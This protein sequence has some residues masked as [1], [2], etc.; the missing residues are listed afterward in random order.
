MRISEI[1]LYSHRGDIRSVK[2]NE[3]GLSIITGESATGKSAIIH[4]IDYCFG[5]KNCHVPLGVIRDKVSWYGVHLVSG[6]AKVFVARKN[7]DLGRQTSSEIFI[8]SQGERTTPAFDQIK[9]NAN[10]EGLKGLLSKM[11]GLQE[12]LHVPPESNT[13][14]PLEANFSHGKIYCFQDQSLIDN[15]NQLFFSQQDGFVAQA[16]KDTLPFFLGAVDADELLKQTRLST[17][18]RSL[19]QLE[20]QQSMAV[21]WKEA[22]ID[23]AQAYLSEARQVR[24]IASENRPTDPVLVFETLSTIPDMN[25]ENYELID[26]DMELDELED[27]RGLLR[28]QYFL[29]SN[30]IEDALNL[31]AAGHDYG[32]ELLEQ[33]FRLSLVSKTTDNDVICP[34]CQ[35]EVGDD[36]EFLEPLLSDISEVAE[37]ISELAAHTPRLQKYISELEKRKDDLRARISV[38]QSQ[39]NALIEQSE[40]LRTARDLRSRQA[41][42]QGRISSFLES[43]ST[44][45]DLDDL[46]TKIEDI[47]RSIRRLESDISGENFHARLRN[48]ESNLET[49]ITDFTR[50]LELEHSAGRTRLDIQNL[51]VVSETKSRSIR[52]AEMGSGDNWVGCHVAVHMALHQWFRSKS[53]PVPSLLVLD[54]PSKAHYP[55]EIKQQSDITDDDRKAVSRLFR[56]LYDETEMDEPFQT[57]V[58]DHVDEKDDWFQSCVVERWRGGEKLVPETWPSY[59]E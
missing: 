46:Q 50:K 18:K 26:A 38:S 5:S 15:K 9:A 7:P 3:N 56:F 47:R 10:L 4:I 23:R 24:L 58:L 21:G 17:L 54:Q 49:L 32:S 20:K 37:R 45:D 55:P 13:R 33:K 22:S 30:R 12:N 43:A 57:I 35:S 28:E 59:E 31:S 14:P 52:L 16:I 36:N 41:R 48:A 39:I 6:D 19:R 25:L 2:L 40:A 34:V 29:V 27:E 1:I 8:E 53:R 51:T 11:V 42:V 44:D